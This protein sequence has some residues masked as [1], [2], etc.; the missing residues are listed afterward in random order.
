MRMP[1][2][3]ATTRQGHAMDDLHVRVANVP[4]EDG[5]GLVRHAFPDLSGLLALAVCATHNSMTSE[6]RADDPDVPLCPLCAVFLAA[7]ELE[8]GHLGDDWK[9]M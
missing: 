8:H 1:T 9:A 6:L 7:A 3:R 2:G 4:T 5:P